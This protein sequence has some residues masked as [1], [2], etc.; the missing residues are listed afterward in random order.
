[1]QI[2]F[3]RDTEENKLFGILKRYIPYLDSVDEYTHQDMVK[4]GYSVTAL[5]RKREMKK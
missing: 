5:P 4:R 2:S 1:M 3:S